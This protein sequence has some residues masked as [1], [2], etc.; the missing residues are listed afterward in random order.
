[1]RHRNARRSGFV[2]HEIVLVSLLPVALIAILMPAVLQVR[3]AARRTVCLNNLKQIGLGMANYEI[4]FRCFPPGT[5]HG[6][7]D[8]SGR[9]FSDKELDAPSFQGNWGW[10]VFLLPFL[11]EESLYNRLSPFGDQTISKWIEQNDNS[12]S[13]PIRMYRC[14][15]DFGSGDN[16]ERLFANPSE[17]QFTA[18]A[19]SNYVGSNGSGELRRNSPAANGVFFVNSNMKHGHVGDGSSNTIQIGERGRM[20]PARGWF[21]NSLEPHAAVAF[22][23]RGVREASQHGL[24]DNMGSGRYRL[25]SRMTSN[26]PGGP[27]VH[28]R[29]AFSSAH[30]GVV[31]F[32]MVDGSARSLSERIDADIDPQTDT[33]TTVEVDSVF[34]RLMSIN[35]GQH[36]GEADF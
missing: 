16:R 34:E 36:V 14:P 18:L 2:L 22:G 31:Q 8:A 1:M 11:E 6:L 3:E 4:T 7:A 10:G 30:R 29:R 5:I 19:H 15:T 9:T 12:V 26:G 13:R 23:T 28:A 24:A 33:T 25:N 17:T 27:V 35:D 32:L 21:D 20:L